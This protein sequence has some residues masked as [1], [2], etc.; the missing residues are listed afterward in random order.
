MPYT[1]SKT[2]PEGTKFRKNTS[3]QDSFALKISRSGSIIHIFPLGSIHIIRA[4]TKAPTPIKSVQNI[5]IPFKIRPIEQWEL[6]L[7]ILA[8]LLLLPFKP[9]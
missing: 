7:S 9:V 1:A 4:P 8:M 5:I 2:K 6:E 3:N